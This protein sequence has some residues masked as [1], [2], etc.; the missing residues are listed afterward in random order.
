MSLNWKAICVATFFWNDRNIIKGQH[1]KFKQERGK[2]SKKYSEVNEQSTSS[3][4]T[5]K[6]SAFDAFFSL[7][8]C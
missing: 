1:K 2:S 5:H 4:V 3:R 6:M 8:F 7:K